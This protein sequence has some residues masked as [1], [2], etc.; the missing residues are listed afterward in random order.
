ME[1]KLP[2]EHASGVVHVHDDAHPGHTHEHS[3]EHEHYDGTVHQH[4]HTHDG[5]DPDHRHEHGDGG[6]DGEA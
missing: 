6:R 1:K 3:H 4:E 2:H 5:S